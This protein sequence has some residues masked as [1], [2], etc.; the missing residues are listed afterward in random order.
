MKKTQYGFSIKT[1]NVEPKVI[2]NEDDDTNPRKELHSCQ[3]ILVYSELE[4]GRHK[5]FNPIVEN[6]IITMADE[7]L[8][9]NFFNKLKCEAK[10]NIAFGFIQKNLTDR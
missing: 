6:F 5:F 7:K 8:Y 9:L 3:H 1:T 10:V 2:M 4:R